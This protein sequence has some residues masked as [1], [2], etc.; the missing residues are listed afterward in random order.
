MLPDPDSEKQEISCDLELKREDLNF[1]TFVEELRRNK[2]A[3]KDF[4]GFLEPKTAFFFLVEEAEGWR[5]H[6]DH[7]DKL[8]SAA[9]DFNESCALIHKRAGPLL[10]STLGDVSLLM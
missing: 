4:F 5:K 6:D 1:C 7:N 10:G 2:T 3:Q 9:E 8:T